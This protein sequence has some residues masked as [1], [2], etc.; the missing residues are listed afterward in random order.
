MGWLDHDRGEWAAMRDEARMGILKAL[1]APVLG[2]DE[3][4]D[5]VEH[6]RQNARAA[7]IGH[8][9]DFQRTDFRHVRLPETPGVAL[10]NP[11]YGERLGDE[12]ELIP[13]YRSIGEVVGEHWAGWRLAV[14]TSN[15]RLARK[16]KLPVLKQTPFF[17]GSLECKLWEYSTTGK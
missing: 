13:L 17:N 15:D 4:T 2:S 7:G 5:A 3:R 8:A 1:P 14:F 11:P 12:D 10:L 9:L 16:V 6:A